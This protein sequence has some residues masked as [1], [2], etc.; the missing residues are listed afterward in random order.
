MTK[1]EVK[2][3]NI[4]N[5]KVNLIIIGAYEDEFS[6]GKTVKLNGTLANLD[7][8]L[9]K[10]LTEYAKE[11]KFIAKLGSKLVIRT[12]GKTNARKILIIGLGKRAD[13]KDIEQIRKA[14]ANAIRSADALKADTVGILSFGLDT[15]LDA[16]NV[17]RAITEVCL[18]APYKFDKYFA[19][20]GSDKN[21]FKGI[22]KISL[23]LPKDKKIDAKKLNLIKEQVNKGIAGAEGVLTARELIAEPP[24]VV[25][26]SYLAQVAQKTVKAQKYNGLTV[27]ILGKAQCEKLKMGAFLAVGC[28]SCCEPK[29]IHYHYKPKGK[30]KKHIAIVGK[31]VTFDSGGLSLKPSKA[32][33]KMKYDMAG[34]ASVIG[35]MSVISKI[36][37]NV[38]VTAVVAAC[39]NMP[40]GS[41][42]RP[43]D[44]ITSMSGKT[45]EINNTDAEGRVTLAD[46]VFYACKQKPDQVIDIA[47]LTGAVVVALG[48]AAAGLM[49]NNQP[50]GD[51]IKQAFSDSGEKLWQLPLYED[52]E[53]AVLKGTIADMLNAGSGGQAG[54]QNGAMFIKQFVGDTPWV[55]LDI[56][57]VCWPERKDTNY[58]P[59]NNPAGF[60]V[61]GFIRHL[62]KMS[63]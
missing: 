58:T 40:G 51:Q 17:T 46:S 43:G 3:T 10:E 32:M 20:N 11:E 63:Q 33:E 47:T 26:P 52:Y 41:A 6:K 34:S 59:K 60:G 49:T 38:E 16:A 55:H 22:Q 39:E 29:L 54:S 1:L 7:K 12:L 42:Y 62:E 56:A 27:K 25:N 24:N 18:L 48:E 21:E 13:L 61:L 2:Q 8:A 36:Q 44:V 30:A 4:E 5:E 35:L 19:K 37:P 57:G 9:N 14:T 15:K 31:G 23:I 53:D 45:I 28:G 50:F